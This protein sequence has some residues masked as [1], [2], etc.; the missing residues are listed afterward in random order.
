MGRQHLRRATGGAM[1]TTTTWSKSHLAAAD[2]QALAPYAFLAVIGKRV[3]H[4]GGRR[5]TEELFARAD[6]QPGQRV[7]DL[8]CGVGTPA[9]AIAQRFGLHVTAAD[10]SALMRERAVANVQSAGLTDR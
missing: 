7:L 3:I 8:G 10:L 4:P 2:V 5:S 9:L 6:F 1:A